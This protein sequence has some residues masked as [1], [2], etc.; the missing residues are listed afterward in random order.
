M[1]RFQSDDVRRNFSRYEEFTRYER[2]AGLRFGVTSIAWSFFLEKD[3]LSEA[4]A[5]TDF[6]SQ[7]TRCMIMQ[8]LL[9]YLKLQFERSSRHSSESLCSNPDTSDRLVASLHLSGGVWHLDYATSQY[10]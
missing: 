2:M 4:P 9:T 10:Y 8:V 1:L 5:S 7:T 6:K 3:R